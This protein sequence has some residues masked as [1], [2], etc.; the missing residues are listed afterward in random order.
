MTHLER[1]LGTIERSEVDR[2]ASWLGEPVAEALPELCRHFGVEDELALKQKL[3]DDVYQVNVPYHSPVGNHIACA[4]DFSKQGEQDYEE[5]TLTAPGYFEDC[6]DPEAVEDF[7]WPDPEN[8][9][10]PKACRKVVERQPRDAAVMGLM[11]SA[12]FQDACA[13]FGMETALIKMVTEPEMFQ[14]VIDRILK[15]YLKAN[16]IF[17]EATRGHL[18]AVLIGNDFG[19][20]ESLM[21]SPDLLRKHVFGG[22]RQLIEQAHAYDLKVIHHSCGSIHPIIGDLVKLG[23]DAIHPIQALAKDM[24]AEKLAED[25]GDR[26]SFCGGIDAQHLLVES[27]PEEVEERVR[28]V[29]EIFPTGLVV[30]PSHEAILPDTRVKNIEAMYRGIRPVSLS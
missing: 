3:D 18:H 30:S 27:S 22:T 6:E 28:Q 25:F 23:A 4:F 5:R 21:L 17:Y 1:F 8:H 13:A 19:S 29:V 26:M 12:H 16:E 10:D 2:P 20:Q 24:S 15:F 9:I 14:A 11:W 7:D